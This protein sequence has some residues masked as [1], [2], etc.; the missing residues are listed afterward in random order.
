MRE[1]RPPL[2]RGP[3]LEPAAVED[4][5]LRRLEG[6]DD[7]EARVLESNESEKAAAF[8]GDAMKLYNIMHVI[9]FPQ[10]QPFAVTCSDT[11]GRNNLAPLGA[12]C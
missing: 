2:P 3:A 11:M 10:H 5:V 4:D 8:F 7:E 6:R 9:G 12:G 1:E